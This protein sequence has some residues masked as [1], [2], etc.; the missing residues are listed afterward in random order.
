MV[1]RVKD[2]GR[3]ISAD[4]IKCVF[5]MFVQGDDTLDR[6]EGGMGVGL[7][8]VRSLVEMHQGTID[9]ES[10]G[11]DKGSEFAVRL[12]KVS[13]QPCRSIPSISEERMTRRI[14]LVED[15]ND[16]REMMKELLVLEGHDVVATCDNGIHGLNAVMTM[17]P[18][19]AILDIGIPEMDG[20][21][22][23]RKIREGLGRSIMLVAL[24]GYG[25]IEDQVSTNLAGFD[26]HL[27]KPIDFEKLTTIL[28]R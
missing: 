28:G 24:T 7:A 8:L 5:N 18:D 23:A 21:Q 16:A 19:V 10:E 20:Y 14:V 9:V 13:E 15:D 26:W 25:R 12:P 1:I 17:R 27:V 3:G 4:L 11:I 2:N 22:L 6:S